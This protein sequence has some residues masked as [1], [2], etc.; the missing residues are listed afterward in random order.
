MRLKSLYISQ[1]KNLTDFTLNFDSNS[2]IDVFVGKNGTGKSNLFEAIIKIFQHLY[3]FDNGKTTIDFNYT[4]SYTI[5]DIETSL[6]WTNGGLTI[7]GNERKTIGN[8]PL[9]DNVLIYYSGHNDTITELV[10][11][12]EEEFRKRIK[13]A[14]FSE[15]RPFIG[16]SREYKDMLLS[17]FL[18]QPG[19]NIARECLCK[20]L[21]IENVSSNVIMVL[22]RPIFAKKNR[23][24]EDFDPTT[25]FWGAAGITRHFL[26]KL[27]NCVK[28]EF[29]HSTLYDKAK[30]FYQIPINLELFRKQF[31]KDNLIDVFRQFDNLKTLGML[32]L[33]SVPVRLTNGLDASIVH[34][35][36]GQFQSVYI[37][38]II[39]L[40]KNSNC[41]TL[42]DE[43]DA[44][45]HP[46]WQ[47]EFLTQIF[48]ITEAAAKSNHVLM[49]SH[50]AATLCCFET[51]H[52]NLF[53]IENSK[54]CCSKRSKKEVINELSNSFIQYAEDESKLLIDNVIRSSQ[55]PILFV[56]GLSDVFIL[57][58]AYMKLF[59]REDIPILVQDAFSRGFLKSLFGRRDIFD[60]YPHKHFFALF[61]FDDAYDDWRGLGG[62]YIT[63]EIEMGLC[64]KLT[65]KNAH[66]LLLPIPNNQ[67]RAQV[68]DEAN[69]IEKIK[70]KPYFCIEHIFWSVSKLHQWFYVDTKTGLVKFK[71]DK[72]KVK[73][74][75]DV[76]PTLDANSFEPFR[77]MFNLILEKSG[78]MTQHITSPTK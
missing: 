19:T 4:L 78:L 23:K 8:T 58:T 56:E 44:F 2:F 15:S 60:T 71:G 34:F 51:L 47:F 3:E 9:P 6:E 18:M 70:P 48:S 65:D 67:L 54:V 38:S 26:D 12:Y 52:L 10:K 68:W 20:K 39:E 33:I 46:E 53:Q 16:I 28:G 22:Q 72:H 35:S 45:L 49:T 37:Y 61:D 43:P 57:N 5:N 27:V 74:A 29:N 75:K 40:F 7:N 50:S 11:R 66:T 36:D 63:T 30:G 25:H 13:D 24:I 41:I 62:E 32:T 55:K 42:L 76:V 77:P 21:G 69:P 31:A 64:K 73:F 59:P 14:E 17:F 1:Y